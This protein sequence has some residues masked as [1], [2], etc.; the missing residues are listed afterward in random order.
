MAETITGF[1][2]WLGLAGAQR[3]HELIRSAAALTSEGFEQAIAAP[4]TPRTASIVRRQIINP[5][6]PSSGIA[7]T[8]GSVAGLANLSAVVYRQHEWNSQKDAR[9]ELKADERMVVFVDV[10]SA[11]GIGSG[12]ILLTDKIQYVDDQEGLVTLAI[13]STAPPGGDGLTLVRC[14]YARED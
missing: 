10:P 3:F 9:V 14:R 8:W 11:G 7:A 12:I 13:Q 2:R 5:G 6:D 4:T 1:E